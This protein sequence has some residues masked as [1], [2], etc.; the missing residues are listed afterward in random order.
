MG[1]EVRQRRCL[2]E[3][4]KGFLRQRSAWCIVHPGEML[5]S[6]EPAVKIREQQASPEDQEAVATNTQNPTATT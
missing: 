1:G 3:E 4:G 2:E 5:C 6:Y